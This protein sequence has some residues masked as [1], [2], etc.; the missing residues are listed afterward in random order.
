[1]YR[2]HAPDAMLARVRI[3]PIPIHPTP[4]PEHPELRQDNKERQRQRN[5]DISVRN[6]RTNG[7]DGNR[8]GH[9]RIRWVNACGRASLRFG[10]RVGEVARRYGISRWRLSTWRSA[11]RRRELE[12]A[13]SAPPAFAALE[14]DGATGSADAERGGE[15]H[16]IRLG[17]TSRERSCPLLR[18]RGHGLRPPALSAAARAQDRRAGRAAACACCAGA[19][20]RRS[21]ACRRPRSTPSCALGASAVGLPRRVGGALGRARGGGVGAGPRYVGFGAAPTPRA[22]VAQEPVEDRSWAS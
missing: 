17:T 12:V 19:R 5:N 7:T 22:S 2:V 4:R 11:A 9:T 10:K 8:V 13:S 21:S 1:M 15:T 20:W 14:V 18:A 3:S 6:I 16:N